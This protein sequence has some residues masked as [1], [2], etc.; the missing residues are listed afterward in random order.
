M[1]ITSER[2]QILDTPPSCVAFCPSHSE[3][4]AIGTYV[5]HKAETFDAGDVSGARASRSQKRTPSQKRTGCLNL[6]KLKG[7]EM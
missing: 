4:F 2:S 5:L 3:Y 1:D 7:S 6:Y